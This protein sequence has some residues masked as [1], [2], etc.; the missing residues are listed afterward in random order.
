MHFEILVEDQ[1]GKIFLE[2]I[3][4]EL[5]DKNV[6]TKNIIA[7]KGIGRIPKNLKDPKTAYQKTLLSKLFPIMKAFGKMY[8]KDKKKLNGVLFVI[9]DLDEKCLKH[10][11]QQLIELLENC[12]P[13]PETKFCIAIEEGEAWL[14]G[15]K[16]AVKK[17]YP[18]A[19]GSVLN[20]YEYDS[21]CGTWEKLA[22][23]IHKGGSQ[24]L[25][26]NGWHAAGQ[27]KAKWAE[28]IGKKMNIAC[29]KS[30]SFNYFI[31]HIQTFVEM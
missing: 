20:S 15:D 29:N 10:F 9:C 11:R 3:I 14:L 8:P 16:E 12:R 19:K 22:D 18:N 1:S 28:Q 25:K 7:F 13:K 4:D 23:A 5:I 24:Q 27:A 30:P 2:T 21:I 26:N 31:K 17:A 6:H